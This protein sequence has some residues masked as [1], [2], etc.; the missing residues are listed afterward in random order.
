MVYGPSMR[1]AF[2]LFLQIA[3][4]LHFC[5]LPAWAADYYF[6]SIQ[7]L[8]EQQVGQLVLPQ[9][10]ERLQI[11]IKIT[12]MPGKRAEQYACSGIKDGEIMRIW[13]YGEQHPSVIRVPT[14]Y[15]QLQ[16]MAFAMKKGISITSAEDL[17]KYRLVKVR[18][19]KHT[20]NITQEMPN[21]HTVDDTKIMMN[22]L[23][24]GRADIALTS[25]ADGLN[26]L[27]EMKI[28]TVHP[29]GPP[30][31]T[32]DL[33]H[34]IHQDQSHLVDKVNKAILEMKKSGELEII[35]RQ[36]EKQVLKG[37]YMTIKNDQ[38]VT[39]PSQ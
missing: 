34:Y 18:G 19:V 25:W 12:A 10:Y 33:F 17:I 29:V 39:A 7:G 4:M 35:T 2:N 27:N 30:L 1:Y 13:S 37:H 16:T 3:I 32:L 23:I 6:A 8:A 36:A 9:I 5:I 21:V 24:E 28:D 26:T 22:F 11:P 20:D 14:P 31:A 15:Y 38:P